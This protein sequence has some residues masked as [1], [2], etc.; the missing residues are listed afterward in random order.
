[1]VLNDYHNALIKNTKHM[2]PRKIQQKAY[3]NIETQECLCRS[4]DTIKSYE[5]FSKYGLKNGRC[6]SCHKLLND[7][8]N[9]PSLRLKISC[10]ISGSK[11]GIERRN[12]SKWRIDKPL[13]H[14]LTFDEL[15]SIYLQQFGRCAYS[16]QWLKLFGDYMMSLERKDT[17]IGYTKENCCLVCLEFNATDWSI[18]KCDDDTRIGSSGWNAAKVKLVVDN[19]LHNISR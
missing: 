19:Y 1:M 5:S 10:L 18:A 14:T 16:N 2:K 12:K 6:I 9:I 8:R 4:C 3:N 11:S 17:T 7:K 15:L 13:I